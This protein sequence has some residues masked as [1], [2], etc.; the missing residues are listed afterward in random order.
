MN[1]LEFRRAIGTDPRNLDETADAH[2]VQCARCSDAL[3]RALGFERTL[4]AAFAVPVPEGLADRLLLAQITATRHEPARPRWRNW[5][6]AAALLLSIG[7]G[8]AFAWR[9]IGLNAPMSDLAIA[10][11]AHEPVALSSRAIVAEDDVRALFAALGAPL[12]HAPGT[13]HYLMNCPLGHHRVAHLVLQ[14]EHG[15]VTALYV[16]R[17]H[18]PRQDFNRAGVRGRELPVADGT[19]ILLA[20]SDREFDAIGAEFQYAFGAGDSGAV[21]AP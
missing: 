19:L 13:V 3:Q 12:R 15:P 17:V 20:A 16:P 9:W 2:R 8:A 6:L 21:G 11:L 14:R 5:S 4:S 1:C 10:H 18:E 7:L